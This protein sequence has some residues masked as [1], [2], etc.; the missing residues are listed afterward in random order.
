MYASEHARKIGGYKM[1]IGVDAN[2]SNT[3]EGT[4][5]SVYLHLMAGE[6]D[7]DNL[8]WPFHGEVTVQL[9]NQRN[10]GNHYESSLIEADDYLLDEFDT[11]YM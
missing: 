4:H 8:K 7:N 1:C 11:T 2:G 5:I 9:L 10:N 6:Y 3:G